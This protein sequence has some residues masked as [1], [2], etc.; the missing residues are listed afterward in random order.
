MERGEASPRGL[1]VPAPQ[2]VS[3]LSDVSLDS[4]EL[5][6]LKPAL[7]P[8]PQP[9]VDSDYA[10]A[11]DGPDKSQMALV[12]LFMD[13]VDLYHTE[14]NAVQETLAE[15]LAALRIIVNELDPE[16]LP[17]VNRHGLD[18]FEKNHLWQF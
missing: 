15:E 11:E 10:F 8:A 14:H 18:L 12:R 4:I 17:K 5:K 16:Q 3:P 6:I 7:E 2:F 9:S 13:N 1:Q